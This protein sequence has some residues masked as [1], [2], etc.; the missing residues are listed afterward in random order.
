MEEEGCC[1]RRSVGPT[2]ARNR[3]GS[4]RRDCRSA[5][6]R[7]NEWRLNRW[8]TGRKGSRPGNSRRLACRHSSRQRLRWSKNRRHS[9]R[10]GIGSG[11]RRLDG[12]PE[13]REGGCHRGQDLTVGA[14]HRLKRGDGN[15]PVVLGHRT[16]DCHNDLAYLRGGGGRSCLGDLRGQAWLSLSCRASRDGGHVGHRLGDRPHYRRSGTRVDHDC[17]LHHIHGDRAA[18]TRPGILNQ[19]RCFGG[20]LC[21]WRRGKYLFGCLLLVRIPR[22]CTADRQ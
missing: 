2:A 1:L 8:S 5:D 16:R 14:W 7:R 4:L 22:K 3:A 20:H 11:Q 15:R 12:R 18:V 19:L 10:L 21:R 17:G 6:R 13:F 9:P